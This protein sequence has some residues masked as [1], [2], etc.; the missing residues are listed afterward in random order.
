MLKFEVKKWQALKAMLEGPWGGPYGLTLILLPAPSPSSFL[1]SCNWN[2]PGQRRLVEFCPGVH[3][4]QFSIWPDGPH[5][6]G[7]VKQIFLY[8]QKLS[9]HAKTFRVTMLPCYPGL[10]T[11]ESGKILFSTDLAV[12]TS[13]TL[14]AA[15]PSAPFACFTSDLMREIRK[16]W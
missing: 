6:I 11:S 1:E 15:Q 9:R 3:N 10:S 8:A 5:R 7:A 4:G 13:L 2:N 16:K 12:I 14:V